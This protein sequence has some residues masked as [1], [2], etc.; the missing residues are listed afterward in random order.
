MSAL[1]SVVQNAGQSYGG[2]AQE[3]AKNI[4][5]MLPIDSATA[6][7]SASPITIPDSGTRYSY[8]TWIRLRCDLAPSDRVENIKAWYD[9]GLPTPGFT[10]TVNS[11]IVS[12]YAA[13]INFQS[14]Q[15]ARI[16]FTTKNAVGNSIALDGTLQNIGDYSSYLCF[17]L[18]IINTALPGAGGVDWIC[19][20]D[21][22]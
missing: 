5:Y 8:E 1:I 2:Y 3:V 19:Q 17:Q 13:P 22:W 7:K 4:S 21:E 10:L 16:D 15:G 12:A 14:S 9:S 20:Y 11:D 6:N 18:E